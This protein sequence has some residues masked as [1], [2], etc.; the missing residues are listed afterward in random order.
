MLTSIENAV[1]VLNNF[2]W[3]WPLVIF[4]IATSLMGTILLKGIQFRYFF[5]SWKYVFKPEAGHGD[6]NNSMSPIQAFINTLSASIGNGSLAGMAIAVFYGGPGAGFWI[7]S[8]GFFTL[9]IRFLEVFAGTYFVERTPTGAV[10]GGPMVYL[11]RVPGG[12]VLPAL[13]AFFCLLLSFIGGN[14]MQCNSINAGLERILSVNP[15]IVAACLL[16]F[17]LY[18]LFGGAQ[19]IARAAEII[20]PFKVGLFFIPTLV[21][22]AFHGHLLFDALKLIVLS[23]FTSKAVM[24]GAM[25]YAI[26]ESIRRGMSRVLNATEIGLGT[27][28]ILFGS[29]GTKSP[30][31]TG[32]MSMV[33]AFVSNHLVCF[34][35]VVMLVVTGAWQTGLN[36]TQMTQAAYESVFGSVG[37]WIVALLTISFGMGV[38]VAYAFIGRECWNYL[39]KGKYGMVYNLIFACMAVFGTL[40]KVKLVWDGIDIANAGLIVINLYALLILLKQ[41]RPLVLKYMRTHEDTHP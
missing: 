7:F 10:R 19:R 9:V 3:G 39:T 13:Y 18:L 21:V 15:Y 11:Q 26:Q 1:E 34:S 6:K 33:T 40:A 17:V 31:R 28:A 20:I 37:S 32:I 16:L 27:S 25:G 23:A 35:L 5:E 14:A 8:L 2:L 29:T 30:I 41:L 12:A 38:L 24:S 22:F 4:V 36:G